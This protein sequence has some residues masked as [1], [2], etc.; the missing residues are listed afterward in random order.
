M[1]PSIGPRQ[2]CAGQPVGAYTF[3]RV[4]VGLDLPIWLATG[5][6]LS[7]AAGAGLG[8]IALDVKGTIL[9]RNEA[10]L[11]L[12]LGGR[13]DFRPPRMLRWC[14]RSRMGRPGHC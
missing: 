10:A 6:D 9:D 13:A 3:K 11:G 5:G 14:S 12:A 4:R 2:C 1:A 8:D 7:N